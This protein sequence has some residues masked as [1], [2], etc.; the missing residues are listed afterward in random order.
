MIIII[1]IIIIIDYHRCVMAGAI[2]NLASVQ[3]WLIRISDLLG[4]ELR[5]RIKLFSSP[6]MADT[7]IVLF[8][9]GIKP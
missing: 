1:I 9:H 7:R 4:D 8:V 3:N 5:I 2:S 6:S